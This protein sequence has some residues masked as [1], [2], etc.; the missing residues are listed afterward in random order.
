MK[1]GIVLFTTLMMIMAL[2]SIVTIFLKNTSKVKNSITTEFA[3][4]QTNSI[5]NNLT[6][7]LKDV[8]FDEDTI[9]YGSKVPFTIPLKNNSSIVFKIES[10]NKY[11]DINSLAV[12][13]K[14]KNNE[15]YSQF[16]SFLYQ[17]NIRDPEFFIDLL[18]DTIDADTIEKNSGSGSEIVLNNPKFRNGKI[19]TM[20]HFKMI[21]DY[22]F[23]VTGDKLIY[24]IPFNKLISFHSAS[25]DINFLSDRLIDMIFYDANQFD[26][27][28]IKKHNTIYEKLDDLPFDEA[29]IKEISKG[30]FAHSIGTK[31]S[32]IKVKIVLQYGEQFKSNVEFLYNIKTK[33]LYDYTILNIEIS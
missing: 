5:M 2:L 14:S 9:F 16:V 31:S 15:T 6:S 8:P 17:Y 32:V 3:L 13:I 4:I 12:S 11:L 24:N 22:Y 26:L 23:S 29:Y 10:A 7:Y 19:Y 1:K 30:R 18:L 25:L 33:S 21:I 27:T 20:K 28:S